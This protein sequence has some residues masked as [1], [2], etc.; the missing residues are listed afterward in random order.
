MSTVPQIQ[1]PA[2]SKHSIPLRKYDGRSQNGRQPGQ[3]KPGPKPLNLQ[4]LCRT[5]AKK[6]LAE[7][8]AIASY[9]DVYR[10]AWATNQLDVCVRLRQNVENRLF[11]KPHTAVPPEDGKPTWQ[12]NRLQVAIENLVI[13]PSGKK[14]LKSAKSKRTDGEGLTTPPCKSLETKATSDNCHY[15]YVAGEVVDAS[16]SQGQDGLAE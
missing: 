13:A 3:N 15:D 9:A 4:R 7:F 16:A 1:A 12:D 11:G 5:Q 8:D 14:Q 6:T 2:K 10:Q